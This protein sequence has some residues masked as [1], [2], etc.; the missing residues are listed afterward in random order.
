MP[1][2]CAIET[3]DYRIVQHTLETGE[4]YFTRSDEVVSTTLAATSPQ[5]GLV[6]LSVLSIYQPITT[7]LVFV[8]TNPAGVTVVDSDR[9]SKVLLVKSKLDLSTT[10]PYPLVSTTAT[11][12]EIRTVADQIRVL[13]S[14]QRLDTLE[15]LE[16]VTYALK[17]A[18][19]L[20]TN[21]A[22]LAIH[23]T[24]E[25]LSFLV[26]NLHQ[27]PEDTEYQDIRTSNVNQLRQT[28]KTY[29]EVISL[30]DRFLERLRELEVMT[31]Q[32]QTQIKPL[33]TSIQEL[34]S[35]N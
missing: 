19:T 1:A 13:A 29:H 31:R 18:V 2:P 7:G 33:T 14:R 16:D 26:Q 3:E 34:P 15:N 6:P 4:E 11:P 23:T 22:R 8:H 17:Q 32:L 28:L 10:I 9:N 24:D 20:T 35:F 21:E 5:I 27:I 30:I 25:V 12:M